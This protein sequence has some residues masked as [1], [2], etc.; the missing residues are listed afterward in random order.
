MIKKLK[1]ERA[2]KRFAVHD[3]IEIA[4]NESTLAAITSISLSPHVSSC[5]LI[6]L[7]PPSR[8]P[9]SAFS[10]SR[11]GPLHSLSSSLYSISRIL[12][13]R[14]DKGPGFGGV[15]PI[16]NL[17]A[18]SLVLCL[19]DFRFHSVLHVDD[20]SFDPMI[21]FPLLNLYSSHI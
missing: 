2:N 12:P 17:R 18:C 21:P 5:L 6:L 4:K 13:L 19:H 7:L 15:Q 10:D 11:A 16:V 8:H 20:S 14:L 9:P 3:A 1:R